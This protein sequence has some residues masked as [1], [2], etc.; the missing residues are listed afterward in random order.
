MKKL[1]VAVVAIVLAGCVKEKTQA[2][3]DD[4]FR[5]HLSRI[6]WEGHCY[7]KYETKSMTSHGYMVNVVSVT[8]DPDCPCVKEKGGAK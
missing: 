6:E 8:H 3:R 7:V 4:E 1:L 2:D 5:S